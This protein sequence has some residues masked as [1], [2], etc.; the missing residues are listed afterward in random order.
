MSSNKTYSKTYNYTFDNNTFELTGE[1]VIYPDSKNPIKIVIDDS[2]FN[3]AQQF[4]YWEEVETSRND[5]ILR[6]LDYDDKVVAG[7]TVKNYLTG[8]Y[9]VDI[10]AR[11]MSGSLKD[12]VS[13]QI[14]WFITRPKGTMLDDW[15]IGT[16][17]G[18]RL[19]ANGGDD[20]MTGF[21]G[22]D[23]LYGS[24]GN[25]KTIYTFNAGFGTD[26]IVIGKDSNYNLITF[27][28]ENKL[29]ELSS[30]N[31]FNL[32][33]A[34]VSVKESDLTYSRVKNDLHIHVNNL[35]G[36]VVLKN[37]LATQDGL[38]KVQF[39][40]DNDGNYG[41]FRNYIS[42]NGYYYADAME[43]IK[44]STLG[45]GGATN[46]LNG[47]AQT[48]GQLISKLDMGNPY[49][50]KNQTLTD[51][52]DMDERIFGGFGNDR[53]TYTGGK[54]V[55]NSGAGNDTI[56]VNKSLTEDDK[57]E[58]K[59]DAGEGNNN[60][61]FVNNSGALEVKAG[62]GNNRITLGSDVDIIN[63][64]NG[65]DPSIQLGDGR[66][67][68]SGRNDVT[69][70]KIQVGNGNN[71]IK[72]GNEAEVS[73]YAGTGNNNFSLGHNTDYAFFDSVGGNNK[74]TVGN[75]A[76]YVEI[77]SGYGN[78]TVKIGANLEDAWIATGA[79][80]DRIT[81]GR[82]Y[83]P[84][85][86][87]IYA[88]EGNDII[89][90]SAMKNQFEMYNDV[91]P[92]E[93]FGND[94]ITVMKGS[95]NT[96]KFAGDANLTYEI[97][98]NDLIIRTQYG[99]I[100]MKNMASKAYNLTGV[101]IYAGDT[102]TNN[103]NNIVIT[104]NKSGQLRAQTLKA[105]RFDDVMIGSNFNDRIT[106]ADGI[107]TV[108]AGAGK[109]TITLGKGTATRVFAGSGDDTIKISGSGVHNINICDGDGN[110]IING[111]TV[112]NT[113]V[114]FTFLKNQNS[115][116]LTD[117]E[118]LYLKSGNDLI[119]KRAYMDN[120]EESTTLKNYFRGNSAVTV[121]GVDINSAIASK[122]L[123]LTGKGRINGTDSDDIIEGSNYNDTIDG[124]AG[125]DEIFVGAGRDVA[126]GGL[127]DDV[128][129]A[130]SGRNE[131]YGYYKNKNL[132][133][134]DGIN[135]FY[136]DKEDGFD[137][138]RDELIVNNYY[139]FD[140]NDKLVIN[141]QGNKDLQVFFEVNSSGTFN[142]NDSNK[143]RL[144]LVSDVSKVDKA[145]IEIGMYFGDSGKKT[146]GFD[147]FGSVENN[148]T[149]H[150]LDSSKFD[151][152]ASKVQTWLQAND[153]N[154]ASA[155]LQKGTSDQ[156]QELVAIYNPDGLW[157]PMY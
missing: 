121:N 69:I 108:Y 22:N 32:M 44:N 70:S 60:I 57:I 58:L 132:G 102:L 29:W 75:N 146:H 76:D 33:D 56:N 7:I 109:D 153:F 133:Y 61:K 63:Y 21:S 80:N 110:D 89:N 130:G 150:R 14:G 4:G 66:N 71:T 113:Q 10:T 6:F 31:T 131:F 1:S 48:L 85:A 138:S 103:M 55:I 134:D 16:N 39:L 142:V 81:I 64:E 41:D 65:Y 17:R 137:V 88:G 11:G 24:N 5:L 126:N 12:F 125:D 26:T 87:E 49:S 73:V 45:Y 34:L 127:G 42:N 147:I 140:A 106:T 38:N 120:H 135:T 156:I 20:I 105:T 123:F 27:V 141:C 28:D 122:G 155:V 139:S 93:N 84:E 143:N 100:T 149:G 114:H 118:I 67:T 90:T 94:T 115:A 116:E 82:T 36:T 145:G 95:Q 152:I 30:N 3:M 98:R 101:D 62:N 43:I 117:A 112:K 15:V 72:F 124:K 25:N 111:V 136:A 9:D 53:I 50:T 91:K 77:N 68:I 52:A 8:K 86:I 54:D 99:N 2:V 23:T 104:N 78:D 92:T 51:I 19:Y 13:D 148:D 74:I 46:L 79:G 83:S 119:I 96:L 35:G 154:T 97:N 144:Y 107:D 59:I 18:D 151:E 129:I 157:V 37:I 40:L 128:L 47:G